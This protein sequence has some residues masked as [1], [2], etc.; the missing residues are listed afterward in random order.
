MSADA[1]REPWDTRSY[2]PLQ[3]SRQ[4]FGTWAAAMYAFAC[5]ATGV[6][7]DLRVLPP[8]VVFTCSECG[9]QQRRVMESVHRLNLDGST[10]A[11]QLCQRCAK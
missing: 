3:R 8:L 9:G 6:M 2:E 4:S 1:T 5:A 11:V 10:R 7:P